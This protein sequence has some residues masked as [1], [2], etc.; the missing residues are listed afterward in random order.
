MRLLARDKRNTTR[1]CCRIKKGFAWNEQKT[2]AGSKHIALARATRQVTACH[3]PVK[4]LAQ[5]S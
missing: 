1:D 3:V 2:V 4:V 5:V